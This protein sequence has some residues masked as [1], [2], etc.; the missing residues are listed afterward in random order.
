MTPDRLD[1]IMRAYTDL[2][3]D[4]QKSPPSIIEA[5]VSPSARPGL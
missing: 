5:P 1:E 3:E 4:W 2:I